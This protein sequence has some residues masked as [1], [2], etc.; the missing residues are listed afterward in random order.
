MKINLPTEFATLVSLLVPLT[1]QQQICCGSRTI[2]CLGL[3]RISAVRRSSTLDQC[4]TPVPLRRCDPKVVRCVSSLQVRLLQR[5]LGGLSRVSSL[6]TP[7]GP[8]QCCQS[9]SKPPDPPTSLLGFISLLKR[10]SNTNC[11]RFALRSS[12]INPPYTFQTS[13]LQSFLADP[14]FRYTC[15]HFSLKNTHTLFQSHCT[16]KRTRVVM[17]S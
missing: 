10:G 1:F 12:L 3:R 9:F 15:H 5:A 14:P 8:E 11:L 16:V 17:S 2:C 6:E 7:K 4:S 13:P